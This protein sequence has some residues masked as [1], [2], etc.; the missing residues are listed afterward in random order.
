M[1]RWLLR[2]LIVLAPLLALAPASFAPASEAFA[3]APAALGAVALAQA[4]KASEAGAKEAAPVGPDGLLLVPPLARVVDLPGVLSAADRAALE[5]RLAR[6]ESDNGA[7]VALVIVAST[8][9]EPI[10]DFAN[11]VGSAW[12]IGRRG[13]GDGLLLV[14]A[15]EDRKARIE[16][17]RSLEGAIPDAV[18][19]RVIQQKMGPHF[20]AGDYAGG[21][22]AALDDLLPRIEQERLGV[23]ASERPQ[24]A[25]ANLHRLLPL[26]AFGVVVGAGLRRTLG[27]GRCADR[28]RRRRR[29]GVVR[30]GIGCAGCARRH[31]RVRVCAR[32]G[33]GRA[34]WPRARRARGNLLSRLLGRRLGRRS[35]WRRRFQQRRRRRLLRWRRVRELVAMV[36]K[37]SL[38]RAIRHLVSTPHT[39][40]RVLP[41]AALQRIAQAI[42]RAEEGHQ[43][44]IRFAIEAALPWSYLWRNARPRERALM[45]FSKLRVWD[46]EHNNGVLLYVNLADRAVEIVAD[47]GIAAKVPRAMWQAICHAARDHFRQSRIEAGATAAIE[48]IGAV[49]A[50]HFPLAPGE[51]RANEL[52]DQ[53]VVL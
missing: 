22:N 21:L 50:E 8:G 18:A 3:P 53:P 47:R 24:K 35:R 29:G 51:S 6:F 10:E 27:A 7:Q 4:T 14:V 9:V 30:P 38:R 33:S 12:K 43:G 15:T 46:T 26:L 39:L 34:L 40:R 37:I 42:H 32:V 16:V 2:G 5:A 45:M 44:E 23:P 28:R 11:R 1:R 25:P 17:A 41:A 49:L 20:R 13:V 52:P 48:A 19:K 36:L 31:L